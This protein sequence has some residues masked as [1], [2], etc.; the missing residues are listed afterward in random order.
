MGIGKSLYSWYNWISFDCP[1]YHGYLGDSQVWVGTL[2]T[3]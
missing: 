3:P 2:G 1:T